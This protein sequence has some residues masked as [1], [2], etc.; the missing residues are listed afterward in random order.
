MIKREYAVGDTVWFYAEDHKGEKSAGTIIHSFEHL[1]ETLFVIGWPIESVGEWC[2][3]VREHYTMAPSKDE[4]IGIWVNIAHD[5][6][7]GAK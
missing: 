4:P 2:Y 7:R 3:A 1:G 6:H 5:L